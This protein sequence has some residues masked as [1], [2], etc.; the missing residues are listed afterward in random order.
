MNPQ[1]M[2][3][4]I[5]D[6]LRV[7]TSLLVQGGV[8]S[9]QDGEVDPIESYRRQARIDAPPENIVRQ[10]RRD[11]ALAWEYPPLRIGFGQ[12]RDP[13]RKPFENLESD[14]DFPNLV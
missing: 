14:T 7:C 13:R 2:P 10:E 6:D 9:P 1:P 11:N 3:L 5:R 12:S 4:L 8:R